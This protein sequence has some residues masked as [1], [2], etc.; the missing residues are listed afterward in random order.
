ML[1]LAAH[2]SS[3]ALSPALAFE[4]FGI[5]LWGKDKKQDPDIIDPKTYSVD[6]TTTGD[7]KN[8]DGKEADL[9][10]VIEGA[11]GLVSDAD[12]PASGS[13]GL[14]AKARGD[15]RRILSALYGEG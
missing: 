1:L 8:A 13:A 2:F 14:L 3:F 15:Y 6:V 12:K 4:I 11:S 7:R 9:K 5:H 10:S